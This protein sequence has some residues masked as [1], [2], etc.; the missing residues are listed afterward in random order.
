MGNRADW[1]QIRPLGSGGQSDVFLVRNSAR[2][3]ER[4]NCLQEI[5]LALDG[6]KRAELANAIS[7]YT[8][9]DVI[10]ELGALKLFKIPPQDSKAFSPL[11]ESKEYEA[12]ERLKN[13]VAALS[14][15]RPG[16]PKLLDFNLDERW[17]VTEF[18]PER[19]LEDHPTRY[20]G[21]PVSALKAFRSLVQTVASLH[22][23]SYIHRDIK[24]AN[25]FIS[26]D[27][28]LVLGDFGI[29]YVP[30]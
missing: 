5:R 17:I 9:A 11:P 4:A 27:D 16:L 24:P 15:K 3:S 1:E 12:I 25:V 2:S 8:R 6:D 30:N 14:Q 19:T 18:F 22:K 28:E 29:V 21:N 26:K 13:E 10:S 23:D 20:R 7:S